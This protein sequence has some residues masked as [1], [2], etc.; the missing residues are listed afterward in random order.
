M[1]GAAP[2]ASLTAADA[3]AADEEAHRVVSRAKQGP[4]RAAE[5]AEVAT[6]Y[7]L[8]QRWLAHRAVADQQP[9]Y[10]GGMFYA[11]RPDQLWQALATAQVETEVAALYLREKLCK[12][13]S[14]YRQIAGV[15][16]SM[17]DEPR[18]F[19]GAPLGV[20][21]S[22]GF[23]TVGADGAVGT[24]TLTLEHRQVFRLS[25]APDATCAM[26]LFDGMLSAALQGADEAEQT[27][28]LQQLFGAVL[29]GMM[30]RLQKV[31]LLIG[32]EGSGKSTLQR[33]I[34]RLFPAEAVSAVPPSSWGREYNVAAL[35]GKRLNVV[36]ELS[37]EAPIPAAAFKNVT[38][39]NLIEGRHPTHRPFYFTCTA[40]HLLA[41]NVSPPTTDRTDAFYRRW[42]IVEFRNRVSESQVD[43]YLLEK[44]LASEVPGILA[45][46][47]KG[48]ESVA[49][50]GRLRSTTAQDK[51]IAK[52]K[53][54]ANPVLQFLLDE[55]AVELC[56]NWPSTPTKEVYDNYRRWS[57][58]AG[59]RNPF[60]R[61]HFLDLLDSTG[62]QVGV[63]VRKSLVSGIR[64]LRN[65]D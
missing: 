59:F 23:H 24:E 36:G 55:E 5:P 12:K 47:F 31:G 18:F 62:A 28:L 58:A 65:S 8:A 61:N 30:A 6:H 27:E 21:T 19:E 51:M 32:R 20:V 9:I 7:E 14:D 2:Y 41:A 22:A 16:A 40:S 3:L 60:G 37:D 50:A 52:W 43:P 64:L 15:L 13:G 4:A 39:Q 42:C 57:S 34:E 11:P 54:A 29:F 10:C 1:N 56:G 53:A 48:A 25:W 44:I 46:A 38:G 26:P 33:L 17:T 63:V 35:A 49:A 45:W